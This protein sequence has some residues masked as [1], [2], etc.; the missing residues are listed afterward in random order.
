MVTAKS[1]QGELTTK[2]V[3]VGDMAIYTLWSNLTNNGYADYIMEVNVKTL[4]GIPRLEACSARLW[5]YKG[6]F[7]VP[8]INS[9]FID[10][11]IVD[12]KFYFRFNRIH[13]TN[14]VN[15]FIISFSFNAIVVFL[16]IFQD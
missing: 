14:Q 8:Y 13:V 16:I 11:D 10:P 15:E 4:K 2:N 6:S 3:G 12:G 1:T 7:D 5:N 9:S